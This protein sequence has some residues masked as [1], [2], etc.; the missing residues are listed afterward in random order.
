[1][2]KSHQIIKSCPAIIRLQGHGR[3][4]IGERGQILISYSNSITSIYHSAL[5]NEVEG[6]HQKESTD[7]C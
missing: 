1:M 7:V 6:V 4:R 5:M 3:A 2:A